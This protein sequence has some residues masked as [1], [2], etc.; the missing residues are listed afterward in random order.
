MESGIRF[1]RSVIRSRDALEA[2]RPGAAL[3]FIFGSDAEPVLIAG[4][5][6]RLEP[7]AEKHVAMVPVLG[8]VVRLPA[9]TWLR[10]RAYYQQQNG[11]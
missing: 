4:I 10:V 6:R 3:M 2:Q 5:A 1:R 11:Q 7:A 8:E 9:W